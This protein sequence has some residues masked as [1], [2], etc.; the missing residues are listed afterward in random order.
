MA[1]PP[2][3]CNYRHTLLSSKV[4]ITSVVI[5]MCARA[6]ENVWE[7]VYMTAV[8]DLQ[9]RLSVPVVDL[10]PFT[11]AVEAQLSEIMPLVRQC[12]AWV[13]WWQWGTFVSSIHLLEV[14]FTWILSFHAVFFLYISEGNIVPFTQVYVTATE[15]R[16]RLRFCI[17]YSMSVFLQPGHTVYV[18]VC[19]RD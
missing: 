7:W 2:L 12:A 14:Y 16:C 11:S 4:H 18:F 8:D 13:D 1:F 5:N 15:S 9:R 19:V 3:L 10:L 6:S 17:E